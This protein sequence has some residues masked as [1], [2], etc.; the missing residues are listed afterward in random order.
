MQN[1]SS[2]GFA[3]P[4]PDDSQIELHDQLSNN[5][6]SVKLFSARAPGEWN[7]GN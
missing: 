2:P 7:S 3:V 1:I 5:K 6:F 4:K